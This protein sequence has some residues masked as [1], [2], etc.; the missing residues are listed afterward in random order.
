M[1]VVKVVI[2]SCYMRV[3]KVVRIVCTLINSL[4]QE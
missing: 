4:M 3:V 2:V 1:R